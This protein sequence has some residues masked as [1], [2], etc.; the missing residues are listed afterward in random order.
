MSNRRY[1]KKI[2]ALSGAIL[3]TG[4]ALFSNATYAQSKK[5]NMSYIYFGNTSLY[6]AHVEKTQDSLNIIS[7]NYFN[8]DEDGNL[9]LTSIDKSFIN[10]M[11]N[12]NVKVIPFL[13]NHWD[14]KLGRLALENKEALVKDLY[15]IIMEKNLDGINIDIENLT[16]SDRNDYTEFVK[17]LRK[18]LP[19][20]KV[21]SVA[22][23]PNPYDI[24]KGWQGSYDYKELSKYSDHLV[25]MTY[26]ESY[27]GGP[28]GPVASIDF[29]E[30]SIKYALNEVESDKILLGIP[31]FGRLW[32]ENGEIKGQGISIKKVNELIESYDS[33]IIFDDNKKSPYVT[34]DIKK[35]DKTVY[36]YGREL[37]PGKYTIWYEDNKSIKSKLKLVQKYDLQGTASWSLGQEDEEV[38]NYYKLW[39]NGDYFNDI[40]SHWAKESIL[41]MLKH[42]I[43]NGISEASFSPNKPLTRSQGAVIL[44]RALGLEKSDDVISGFSDVSSNY[45]AKEEID[46]AAYHGI[47]KGYDDGRFLPEKPITREEMAAMLDRV[48]AKSYVNRVNKIGF[49]DISDKRWSYESID[50]MARAGIIKGFEDNTFRPVESVTRGQVAALMDRIIPYLENK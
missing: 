9:K 44:V 50:K 33:K 15:K 6:G 40:E 38:W 47:I 13:S 45:W 8:I 43:M 29:V 1:A 49:D 11:H 25:I 35:Y 37:K 46:I 22:V 5:L 32:S 19:D 28:V 2:V 20:N 41:N 4:M 21:V 24:D 30:N 27:P 3:I 42:N 14:R 36:L 23:A 31:F 39:L 10:Q 18:K 34:I 17:M 26:D 48:V 16:E 7:P 12:E